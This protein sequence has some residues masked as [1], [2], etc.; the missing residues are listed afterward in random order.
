MLQLE[1]QIDE[2]ASTDVI[3]KTKKSGIL[4]RRRQLQ[5]LQVLSR[6]EKYLPVVL[7]DI[8][9][10]YI[11]LTKTC[12]SLM[13]AVQRRL[14]KSGVFHER[15]DSFADLEIV[16]G[17]LKENWEAETLHNKQKGQGPVPFAGGKE[18]QAACE[19]FEDF[20]NARNR[21]AIEKASEHPL[22]I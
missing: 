14:N 13:E 10:D 12:D 2:H 8:E 4:L 6:L 11:T 5:P 9:F 16:Y 17:I 3:Q 21:R 18:L 19:E 7:E 15:T 22:Q 20:F 1:S